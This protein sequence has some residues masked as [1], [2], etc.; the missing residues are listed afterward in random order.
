MMRGWV[1]ARDLRGDDGS[2]LPI[3]R[4]RLRVTGAPSR[5]Q[6]AIRTEPLDDEVLRPLLTACSHLV[7]VLGPHIVDLRTQLQTERD[8]WRNVEWSRNLRTG[9][10]L[11]RIE[12]FQMTKRLRL[13][14]APKDPL[15]TANFQH[16]LRLTGHRDIHKALFAQARPLWPAPPGQQGRLRGGEV[17]EW[18]VIEGVVRGIALAEQ[19]TDSGPG[20]PLFGAFNGF[21][22]NGAMT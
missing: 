3:D 11:P 5:T 7:G 14:W 2:L 13:G 1:K 21:D 4:R 9:Q 22:S 17:D 20:Q 16:P 6:V 12:D 19:L 18:V 8:S 10:P 15:L